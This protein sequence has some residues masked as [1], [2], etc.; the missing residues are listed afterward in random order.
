M[1]TVI[2]DL[3]NNSNTIL[4]TETRYHFIVTDLETSKKVT[5]TPNDLVS[6]EL[7]DDSAMERKLLSLF[8][9]KYNVVMSNTTYHWL[10]AIADVN[11]KLKQDSSQS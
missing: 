4:V 9:G 5:I 6:P 8:P 7:I 10:L 3:I 1:M 11:K 2:S